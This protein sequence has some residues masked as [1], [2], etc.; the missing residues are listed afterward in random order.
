MRTSLVLIIVGTTYGNLLASGA[1]IK[2]HDSDTTGGTVIIYIALGDGD[3][4]SFGIQIEELVGTDNFDPLNLLIG[5]EINFLGNVNL[6]VLETSGEVLLP[7]LM[8]GVGVSV[9]IVHVHAQLQNT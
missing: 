8:K 1:G 7:V 4:E 6:L 5:E 9:I 3:G 2:I